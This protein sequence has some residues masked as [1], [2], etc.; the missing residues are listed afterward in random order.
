[1]RATKSKKFNPNY[2]AQITTLKHK[3]VHPNADRLVGWVI[4]G[5]TVWTDNV[6]YSEGDEVVFFPI[7]CCI[8]KELLS[9]LSLFRDSEL[10]EDKDG[11]GFYESSG[12]VKA[13]KLRKIPSEGFVLK[14]SAIQD[15]LKAKYN[16]TLVYDLGD[17]FDS[18]GELKL[19]KKYTIVKKY[20]QHIEAKKARKQANLGLVEDQFRFHYDT[21]K[22]ASNE[23]I[24]KPDNI[25]VITAKLHGCVHESTLIDTDKGT[26]TIKEIVDNKLNVKVK[27]FDVN[28][29]EEVFCDIDQHYF[30]QDTCDWYEIELEDGSKITIT[31]NNPVWLPELNCYR[32]TEDL[33]VGDVL[34][35]S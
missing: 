26:K 12:R 10:N 28:K 6:N 1:M 4:Q 16:D 27:C 34:L 2:A 25:C 7:E 3:I 18:C 14:V 13:L 8:N 35:K 17:V 32:N 20:T 33:S 23:H 11:K 22:L 5:C 19:C 30:K 15:F 21:Q 9:F 31:G 29:N 24:I